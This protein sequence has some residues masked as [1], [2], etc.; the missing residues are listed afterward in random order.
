M[1]GGRRYCL[2]LVCITLPV[3]LCLCVGGSSTDD[4]RLMTTH[5]LEDPNKQT[6]GLTWK[7]L[8]NISYFVIRTTVSVL[9]KLIIYLVSHYFSSTLSLYGLQDL[10]QESWILNVLERRLLGNLT[11][12]GRVWVRA[13]VVMV[14]VAA[15]VG[16]ALVPPQQNKERDA[17]AVVGGEASQRHLLWFWGGS[18]GDEEAEPEELTEEPDEGEKASETDT[19]HYYDDD[20]T[21]PPSSHTT[22]RKP[23]W[24]GWLGKVSGVASRMKTS[25]KSGLNSTKHLTIRAGKAIGRGAVKVGSAIKSGY[26]KVKLKLSGS[27]EKFKIVMH[28]LKE[29]IEAGDEKAMELMRKLGIRVRFLGD[30]TIEEPYEPPPFPDVFN[31]A[32]DR[33]EEFYDSGGF[34]HSELRDVFNFDP[35]NYEYVDYY[36]YVY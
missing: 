29:K 5:E 26:R 12:A 19:L 21:P 31:N 11:M 27:K 13:W 35:D 3:L 1:T 17:A 9:R 8:A 10:L 20:T 7:A 33:L 23:G 32:K 4:R 36:E 6:A 28:R 18:G 24:W 34:S 16:A 25:F 14:V 2:A 15:V 30:R 22:T